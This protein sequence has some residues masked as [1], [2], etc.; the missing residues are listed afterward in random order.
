[1]KII[2]GA[3]NSAKAAV[4]AVELALVLIVKQVALQTRVLDKH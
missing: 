2:V 4:V 3:P 1:M